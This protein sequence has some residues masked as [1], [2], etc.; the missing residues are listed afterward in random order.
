MSKSTHSVLWILVLGLVSATMAGGV[1]V[2]V[3]FD[4]AV[5]FSGFETF[6]GLVG[7]P[8]EDELLERRIHAAIERELVPRGFKEVRDDP[9]LLIVTHAAMDVEKVIDITQFDY[10]R[11]YQGWKKP[12]AVSEETWGANMGVLV[13]DLLEATEQRVIWR[14]VAT[15]NVAKKPERR[16]EKL[17]TT[18]TKMFKGFPPKFKSKE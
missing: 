17:D 3:D 16:G 9:D 13:V 7:T 1:E 10:W 15:G 11:E 6:G 5:D 4:P 18:M 12:M 8:A 14:A 2:R